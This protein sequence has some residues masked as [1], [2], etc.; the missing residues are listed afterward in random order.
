[1]ELTNLDGALVDFDRARGGVFRYLHEL[2]DEKREG[3]S[4]SFGT[5]QKMVL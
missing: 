5:R 1:M 4:T 3:H 2:V